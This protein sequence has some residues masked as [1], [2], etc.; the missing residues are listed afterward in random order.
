MSIA[1]SIAYTI[2]DKTVR[3]DPDVPIELATSALNQFIRKYKDS[4]PDRHHPVSFVFGEFSDG[5]P[6]YALLVYQT[7]TAYIVR[8]NWR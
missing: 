4:H 6:V 2:Y 5:S 7:P 3:I 8:K 1:M